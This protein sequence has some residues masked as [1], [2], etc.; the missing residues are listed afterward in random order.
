[1][2]VSSIAA[3]LLRLYSL[4]L[5]LTGLSQAVGILAH[6]GALLPDSLVFASALPPFIAGALL[7]FLAPP[8][9]RFLAGRKEGAVHLEGVAEEQLHSTAFLGLGLW[10]AL[11]SFAK[12]FNW[13]HYFSANHS[14]PS[15]SIDEERHLFYEFTEDLLTFAAGLFLVFT[16]RMWAAKLARH[17]RRTQESPL[18]AER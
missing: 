3:I 10:F 1:M 2:P 16:C 13:I 11:P 12:V 15:A 6:S 7:W 5:I 9:S 14:F 8:L 4:S 18:P 17:R